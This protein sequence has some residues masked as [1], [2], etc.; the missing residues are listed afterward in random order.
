MKKSAGFTLIELLI[1]VAI[2]A[3]LAAIAISQYQDY[4]SRTRAT[5]AVAEL[6]GIRTAVSACISEDQQAV[7]CDAGSF[8]I[9]TVAS[10]PP[11]A[12]VLS[13]DSV[14]DGVIT[15]TTG[16]TASSGGAN[17]TYVNTPSALP[18]QAT[19]TWLNNGT[20]CNPVRGLRQGQGDC[21]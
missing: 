1:V 21:P 9:P 19:I 5:G 15:A 13:L 14:V 4:I 20:V 10:F 18:G 12:N 17:L 6:S 3:I 11:T 2:I 16:S 7:D 8:G